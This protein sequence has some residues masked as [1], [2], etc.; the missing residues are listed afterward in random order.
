MNKPLRRIALFAGV[1]IFALL[2][3]AN[4]L[5]FVQADELQSDQHNRRGLIERYSK[6][7]GNIYAAHDTKLTGSTKTDSSDFTYKRTYKNGELWA[8]VTGFSAQI[9]GETLLEGVYDSF[10]TGTD[11][12]LFFDRTVSMLTGEEEGG[13]NV[14]TTLLPS[15]QQAAFDGLQGKEGAA[16][17]IDPETGKILALASTPSYDPSS[18]AG[19]SQADQ[20]SWSAMQK[21]NDPSQPMLNRALR[22]VYPP[23]STFKIITAAA[24]L[25]SGKYTLEG[26]T[27]SPSPYNLPTSGNPLPNWSENIPCKNASIRDAL[28]YSCNNVFAKISDELGNEKM[29]ET[30]EKFG[31]NEEQFVPVR[32]V[33]SS[34]PQ[35]DPDQNAM[36]GIGQG[37][38]T[39]SPL[40][41][42]MATAAIAND[43]TL[44]KP[45]M[46]DTLRAPNLDIIE[47]TEPEVLNEALP[48]DVAQQVQGGME[49]VVN[50]PDGTGA[51]AKLPNVTV[52]GKTGTAQHGVGNSQKPYAWFVSYAKQQDG[53]SP[54]AVAVVIESSDTVREEIGGSTLAAPVAKAVMQAVLEEKP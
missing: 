39:A 26:K 17:A 5:Q 3:R 37:S 45:Y 36:G 28:K 12:R 7:R 22:Q 52:G 1:L 21:K 51:P 13:G 25:E 29:K 44:M 42:A 35:I 15:A 38:V 50:D 30:A 43:G 6:P 18:I 8:P 9:Y 14:H 10:L 48:A 46:V 49:A 19:M 23:G 24:A 20:E 32:S 41:M 54:V 4:W 47:H 31:F 11:D 40:Q 53:S 34:F 27:D 33:A 2:A 16:V